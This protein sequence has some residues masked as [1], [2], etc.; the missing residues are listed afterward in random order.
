MDWPRSSGVM[1]PSPV[2]VEVPTS[3]APRPSA[4]LALADSAPK[5]MPGDGHRDLQVQRL[6]GVAV[7]EDD[8]GIALFAVALQRVAGHGGAEEQQVIEVRDLAL[9]APAADV[10][11]AGGGGPLDVRDG[12]AVEGGGFA[13]A[14]LGG[15]LGGTALGG[16]TV[17]WG[18]R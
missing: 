7:A 5:L 13:Q 18:R 2:V 15:V 8:V 14:Q 6:G 12:G 9:G 10:V 1:P 17:S 4:S 16:E 3:L 11:D